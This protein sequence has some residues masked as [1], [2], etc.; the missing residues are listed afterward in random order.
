VQILSKLFAS[1]GLAPFAPL[2]LGQR[3]PEGNF[4]PIAV[5]YLMGVIRCYAPIG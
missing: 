4:F 5:L 1:K 2:I 3:L